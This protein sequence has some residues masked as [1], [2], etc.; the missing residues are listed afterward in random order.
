[1]EIAMLNRLR[2]LALSAQLATPYV[3]HLVKHIV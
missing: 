3:K 2:L 1:M